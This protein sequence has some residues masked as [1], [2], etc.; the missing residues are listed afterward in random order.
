MKFGSATVGAC[1]RSARL[2]FAVVAAAAASAA[3]GAAPPVATPAG[4]TQAA[5]A[6]VLRDITGEGSFRTVFD[7]AAATPRLVLLLSP[8]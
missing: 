3:I 8:T 7:S 6:S 4:Q 5:P 1:A 2:A